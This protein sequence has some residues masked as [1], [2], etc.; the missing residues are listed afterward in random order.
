[1][2]GGRDSL[3]LLHVSV[4]IR[5]RMRTVQQKVE[6]VEVFLVNVTA[7]ITNETLIKSFL[8][9]NELNFDTNHKSHKNHKSGEVHCRI[10]CKSDSV[11]I[12]HG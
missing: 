1:M 5:R 6:S 3:Q 9:C 12:K 4:A 8:M 10:L 7:V 11:K 2:N